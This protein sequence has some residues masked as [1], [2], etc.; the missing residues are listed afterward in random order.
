MLLNLKEH[1]QWFTVTMRVS[2]SPHATVPTGSPAFCI[3][4]MDYK[5]SI[6]PR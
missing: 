4:Q 6:H 5:P 1:D 2:D 3:L